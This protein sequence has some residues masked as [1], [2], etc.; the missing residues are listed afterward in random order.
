ML[1]KTTATIMSNICSTSR[2]MRLS[3]LSQGKKSGTGSTTH[4][5]GTCSW[6]LTFKDELKVT[7]LG[8]LVTNDAI[9]VNR[10]G[11][12]EALPLSKDEWKSSKTSVIL[13]FLK[14]KVG[15]T[16]LSLLVLLM[17]TGDLFVFSRIPLKPSALKMCTLSLAVSLSKRNDVVTNLSVTVVGVPG[18]VEI[19]TTPKSRIAC[20][21]S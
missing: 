1:R 13:L 2:L 10:C 12:P 6:S 3:G 9:D 7:S 20:E 8:S 11:R 4:P 21:F 17:F 16:T 5:S 19:K 14:D 18:N 15:V